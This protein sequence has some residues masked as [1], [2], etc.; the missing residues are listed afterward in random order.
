MDGIVWTI[1]QDALHAYDTTNLG[2][3][4]YRGSAGSFIKFSTPTIANGKVYVGTGNSLAVFGLP[5]SPRIGVILNSAGN[6]AGAVAPGSIVSVY[7]TN[8]AAGAEAASE[9]PLPNVLGGS[10]ILINGLTAPLLSASPGQINAQVP[11]ETLGGVATVVAIQG[12]NV[13]A[14]VALQVQETAPGIFVALNQD[15]TVNGTGHPAAPGSTL[16]LFVTGLGP[17][18]PSVPTGIA[19][20][21]GP[22]ASTIVPLSANFGGES[23]GVLSA[24]LAPGMVGVFN[25]TLSVPDLAPGNYALIVQAG[26]VASN[27]L[28]VN[29]GQ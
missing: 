17:T 19:A 12:S 26:G 13:S 2:S 1:Q 14:P 21:A 5:N 22:P 9:N 4:L 8:L 24:G 11:Y 7:G 6:R 10:R 28:A 3:E 23:T 29:V 15:G 25:V 16:L 27:S 18:Q 20:P